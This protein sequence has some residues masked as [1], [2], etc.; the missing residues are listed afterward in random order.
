MK[1][2][3][4]SGRKH[5]RMLPYLEKYWIIKA[6][7]TVLKS[8][9]LVVKNAIYL[10]KVFVNQYFYQYLLI[11]NK[12]NYLNICVHINIWKFYGRW[13]SIYENSLIK[14]ETFRIRV[15]IIFHQLTSSNDCFKS[16]LI[17]K[18]TDWNICWNKFQEKT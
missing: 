7:P 11:K 15:W 14:Y 16:R 1:F 18:K 2:R 12:I 8:H 13:I 17:I 10:F 4:F 3:Y 5:R 6:R 9:T